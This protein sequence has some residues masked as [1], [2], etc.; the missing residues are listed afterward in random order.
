MN[1]QKTS[2]LLLCLFVLL[3]PLH[4]QTFKA[5]VSPEPGSQTSEF[6]LF[7]SRL[8]GLSIEPD[9]IPSEETANALQENI[10][11][12]A[13]LPDT[14][15]NHEAGLIQMPLWGSPL[16]LISK[17]GYRID[18]RNLV[19]FQTIGVLVEDSPLL[20]RE[21][22]D[23]FSLNVRVRPVRHYDILVRI[24][25]SGR[26]SAILITMRDFNNSIEKLNVDPD[27][28]GQPFPVGF[29]EEFLYISRSGTDKTA[30]V[31]DRII[32]AVED[33]QKKGVLE[34]LNRIV[35]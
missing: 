30:P 17:N 3:L 24:M 31:M 2:F 13:I 26:V 35:H 18:E 34:D 28:F 11:D 20:E 21:V 10:V 6:F 19:D 8:S 9:P 23:R 25:S 29:K 27:Q 5:A 33:M 15:R 16:V 12:F 4:S 7:L 22:I 14:E 1:R 32:S